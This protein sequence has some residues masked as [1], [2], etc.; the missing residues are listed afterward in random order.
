[1]LPRITI[2]TPCLNGER[3]IAEMLESLQRQAY[4]NLEHLILDGGSTDGTLELLAD[5]SGVTLSSEPDR[6]AHHAIN[7]GL[8]RASGDVVGFIAVDDIYPDGALG[9]AGR[10][11]A[12][13]PEVDV[14][15]GH[16]L[17]FEDDNAGHRH[18]LYARTHPRS[19]GLWLPELTFGVPGIFGCFFR[20]QVFERVGVFDDSYRYTSDRQYLIRI[21]LKKQCS[22]R[23]ER[24][25]IYYR[26]HSGSQTINREKTNLWAISIEYFRMSAA[27]ATKCDDRQARRILLAWNAFE[28]AKLISRAMMRWQARDAF[29]VFVRLCIC[30]PIWPLRLVKAMILWRAVRSLDRSEVRPT[31][32]RP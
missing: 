30:N 23:V 17:V 18:W 10:I 31:S 3:Y 9:T 27:L 28:G 16:S 6:G 19:E 26:M 13:R 7:K 29:R 24:P 21:A 2:I 12:A 15:V 14:V 20:R 5:Y 8:A 32:A 11:F 25:T 4:P 22:A 1:M